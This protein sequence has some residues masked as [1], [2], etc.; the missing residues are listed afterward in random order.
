M[1]HLAADL[2]LVTMLTRRFKKLPTIAS[3]YE[4]DL[5]WALGP[6][7]LWMQIL[8]IPA[9]HFHSASTIRRCVAFLVGIAMMIWVVFSIVKRMLNYIHLRSGNSMAGLSKTEI[10][11]DALQEFQTYCAT[12][13][14]SLSLFI[15]AAVQWTSMWKNVV[16]VEKTLGFNKTFYCT[17]R[18][19]STAASILLTLVKLVRKLISLLRIKMLVCVGN[20]CLQLP[21][22]QI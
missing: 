13:L 20:C 14:I 22:F 17:V 2:R 9:G 11:T 18:K 8:G 4:E 21:M 15:G 5:T 19:V 16:Q 1:D 12:I 7:F 6:I 3:K 10:W